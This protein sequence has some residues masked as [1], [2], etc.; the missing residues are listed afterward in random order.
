MSGGGRREN[1]RCMSLALAVT[2]CFID[3]VTSKTTARDRRHVI[4]LAT[5]KRGVAACGKSNMGHARGT[6]RFSNVH[7][8]SA[9]HFTDDETFRRC[10]RCCEKTGR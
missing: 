7:T 10:V 4:H 5:E 2:A 1:S 8:V 6:S 9:E 3:R